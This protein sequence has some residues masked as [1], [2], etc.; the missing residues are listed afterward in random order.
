ME[1]KKQI[2]RRM[3]TVHRKTMKRTR[4]GWVVASLAIMGASIVSQ[5]FVALAET[6]SIRSEMSSETESNLSNPDATTESTTDS[7]VS[8]STSPTSTSTSSITTTSDTT[9]IIN[10]EET[11]QSQSPQNL[12]AEQL[13]DT[14]LG[15]N[16]LED[17]IS[18]MKQETIQKIMASKISDEYKTLYQNHINEENWSD[19]ETAQKKVNHW[20]AQIRY[21]EVRASIREKY[22]EQVILI[23]EL[24][25]TDGRPKTL[26]QDKLTAIKIE[27]EAELG[28]VYSQES[29]QAYDELEIIYL[30]KLESLEI[31]KE[32]CS[33]QLL[34][35]KEIAKDWVTKK[36]GNGAAYEGYE[37]LVVK[38]MKR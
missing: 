24:P 37:E 1:K 31:N 5:P 20:I 9:E 22:N 13:S 18:E 28:K 26:L 14:E 32:M 4:L 17:Q 30:A 23:S 25:G 2:I 8:E 35:E 34:G 3:E 10:S 27:F 33:I 21:I 19:M 29:V 12:G 36:V 7:S 38:K 15:E 16:T 11:N 6:S